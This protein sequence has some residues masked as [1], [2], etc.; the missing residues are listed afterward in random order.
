MITLVQYPHDSAYTL[1]LRARQEMRMKDVH[2]A[3]I[4][5]FTREMLDAV[6]KHADDLTL[7]T[8]IRKYCNVVNHEEI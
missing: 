1:A 2:V 6:I 5:A 8:I 4:D 3:T 7:H